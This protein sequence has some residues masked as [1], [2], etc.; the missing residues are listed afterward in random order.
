MSRYVALWVS[1]RM[2]TGQPRMTAVRKQ[3]YARPQTGKMSLA[4]LELH[5]PE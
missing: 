4:N 2:M 3:L 5:L 1:S